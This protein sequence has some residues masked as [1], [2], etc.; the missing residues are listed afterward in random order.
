MDSMLWK[1]K[2]MSRR[3]KIKLSQNSAVPHKASVTSPE[4]ISYGGDFRMKRV[5][6]DHSK[7]I[8]FS[9][10]LPCT[11]CLP[12]YPTGYIHTKCGI[13]IPGHNC[14][15]E[16]FVRQKW[17]ISQPK[18]YKQDRQSANGCDM[19]T[20]CARYPDYLIGWTLHHAGHQIGSQFVPTFVMRNPMLSLGDF[21]PS[22]RMSR[23]SMTALLSALHNKEK[24]HETVSVNC[25]VSI[26]IFARR[27][28]AQR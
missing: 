1:P 27:K 26:Y 19:N 17:R 23:N 11:L 24:I 5:T 3:S 15:Y 4:G 28:H 16:T 13:H 12:C 2:W 18:Q 14:W 25:L 6:H 7:G 22:R 21:A 20:W 8:L 9:G 10:I